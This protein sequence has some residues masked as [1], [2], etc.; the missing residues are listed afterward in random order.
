MRRPAI[1]IESLTD[2]ARVDAQT[3]ADI[4]LSDNSEITTEMLAGGVVR[5]GLKAV[6]PK[7][8]VTLRMNRDVAEWFKMQGRGYQERINALLRVY[9]DAHRT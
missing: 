6:P 1:S 2:W 8:T 3:D 7:T 9:M 5:R 4:D